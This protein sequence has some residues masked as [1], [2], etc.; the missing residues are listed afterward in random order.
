MLCDTLAGVHQRTNAALAVALARQFLT[1]YASHTA[2]FAGMDVGTTLGALASVQWPGRAQLVRIAAADGHPRV[3]LALDGAHTVASVQC[4][5]QW[6]SGV[7]AEARREL[8]ARAGAGAPRGR[9]RAMLLFNC[10]YEKRPEH[11]LYAIHRAAG[12]VTGTGA[13]A[14]AG[15]QFER[16]VFAPFDFAKPSK[17]PPPTSEELLARLRALQ[18]SGETGDEGSAVAAAD[19]SAAG[20]GTASASTVKEPKAVRWLRSIRA[21]WQVLNSEG[22][23]SGVATDSTVVA[24][25]MRAAV[26]LVAP[27]ARRVT[28][29][30]AQSWHSNVDEGSTP[31]TSG[32]GEGEGGTVDAGAIGTDDH[33]VVLGT[34]SLYLVGNVLE[35][36][37]WDADAC[38]F[39]GEGV[40]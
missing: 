26:E 33:V 24:S 25:S 10:G 39:H 20:T 38:R 3:T 23:D 14:D 9:V 12:G 7:V 34:G 13:D 28:R 31:A 4:A 2:G 19:A 18:A 1:T 16:A 17:A 40:A 5:A 32:R 21:V 36:L 37:G 8:Q 30:R 35:A 11:L 6:F 15:I 27:Q 22:A 29:A